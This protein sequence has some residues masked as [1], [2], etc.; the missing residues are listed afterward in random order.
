MGQTVVFGMCN[1]CLEMD[2][3]TLEEKGDHLVWLC[4]ECKRKM[5]E[6]ENE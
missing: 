4:E 5:K 6:V 3:I 2:D 1:E